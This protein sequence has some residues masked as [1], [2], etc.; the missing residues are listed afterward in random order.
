MENASCSLWSDQICAGL[1]CVER[2]EVWLWGERIHESHLSSSLWCPLGHNRLLG[3]PP[4]GPGKPLQWHQVNTRTSADATVLC[5]QSLSCN[6]TIRGSWNLRLETK[7]CNGSFIFN[8]WTVFSL[9][10]YWTKC[11][12]NAS[13]ALIS[14]FV[15]EGALEPQFCLSMDS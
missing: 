8:N 7:I 14:F 13:G 12:N 9:H 15:H 11:C 6:K 1:R 5:G 10:S 4:S 2:G 3:A